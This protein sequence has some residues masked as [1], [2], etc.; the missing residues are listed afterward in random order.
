MSNVIDPSEIKDY[1]GKEVGVSD[2]FEVDQER[3]NKFAESTEDYQFI[4]IDEE[5]AAQ[6][7]FGTKG[8]QPRPV[9]RPGTVCLSSIPS[10]D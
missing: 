1:I 9:W 3:I 8:R 5:R 10:R 4:H 2:W 6:T 7:P